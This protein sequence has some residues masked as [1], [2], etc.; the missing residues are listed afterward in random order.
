MP[1]EKILLKALGVCPLVDIC[2]HGYCL[3]LDGF[4]HA[5]RVQ[6]KIKLLQEF[7]FVAVD[8]A[9]YRFIGLK[10]GLELPL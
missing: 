4:F 7:G 8:I 3:L 10:L 2:W 5:D 6:Y 1:S 9:I